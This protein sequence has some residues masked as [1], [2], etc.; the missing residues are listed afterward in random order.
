MLWDMIDAKAVDEVPEL[1]HNRYFG[2][3][4]MMILLFVIT[5]LFMNLFIGVV[6]ETFNHQKTLMS[7]N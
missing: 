1:D 6:M 2:Q 5:L 7:F 4:Y 3:I